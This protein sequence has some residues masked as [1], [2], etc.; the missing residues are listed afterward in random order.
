MKNKIKC[1]KFFQNIQ[2]F[3]FRNINGFVKN[4]H[5]S[6]NWLVIIKQ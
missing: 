6:Y 5:D 2:Y 4:L 3:E 1:Y